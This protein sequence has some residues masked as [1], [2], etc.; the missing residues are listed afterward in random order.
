M[1]DDKPELSELAEAL[2]GA[3]APQEEGSE[4]PGERKL[5]EDREAF[6]K[7]AKKAG[8]R[9]KDTPKAKKETAPEPEEEVKEETPEP[10]QETEDSKK[11]KDYLR[12]KQALPPSTIDSLS[13]DE[14]VEAR[15]SVARREAEMD[16]ALEDLADLRK[17]RD[18]QE[19]TKETEHDAVPAVD[20]D[21]EAM[22][23]RLK[24]ALGEDEAGAVASLLA[25]TLKGAVAP[26][27]AALKEA[28]TELGDIKGV[29]DKAQEQNTRNISSTN[30]SRISEHLPQ[31]EDPEAWA[32]I[33]REVVH[34]LNED[35]TTFST[36]EEAF[37]S[38]VKRM[39][40]ADALKNGKAQE[41]EEDVAS[42]IEASSV[43][44]PTEKKRP[45]KLTPQEQQLAVFKHLE[46]HPG[47]KEGARK[48]ARIH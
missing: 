43:T 8:E 3:D 29:M 31:L 26:L 21:V 4:T 44:V 28:Q 2:G 23:A 11:A 32:A 25:D 36:V 7:I 18:E 42:Q 22:S 38:V 12:L 5:R 48:A 34:T 19:A 35:G 17:Q 47:D 40:G 46:A 33:E 16:R 27:Q 39:F 45:R 20:I 9:K 14:A 37:D 1:P 41:P 30:Q 15:R 10:P 13:P 6:E 24:D